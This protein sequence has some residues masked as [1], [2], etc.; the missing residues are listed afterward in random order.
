MLKMLNKELCKHCPPITGFAVSWE[1]E[2]EILWAN[3]EVWCRV[4][5][6]HV[7]D[8]NEPPPA[9]CPRRLEHA[10]S[11]VYGKDCKRLQ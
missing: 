10:M 4:V 1:E 3:D 6:G 11:A 7:I 2:D 8:I 9:E 5:P